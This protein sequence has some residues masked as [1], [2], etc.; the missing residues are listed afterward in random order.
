MELRI[1]TSTITNYYLLLQQC[2][3]DGSDTTHD[4]P[5]A[6]SVGTPVDQA[7]DN[8]TLVEVDTAEVDRVQHKEEQDGDLFKLMI[9]NK[10]CNTQDVQQLKNYNSHT[11]ECFFD[12]LM[13]GAHGAGEASKRTCTTHMQYR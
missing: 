12:K 3:D 5:I 1:H 9:T 7:C 6:D 11:S 8:G 13:A 4:V 10:G 2:S